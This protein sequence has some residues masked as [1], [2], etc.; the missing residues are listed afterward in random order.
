MNHAPKIINFNVKTTIFKKD[1]PLSNELWILKKK[2][3][4]EKTPYP[5]VDLGRNY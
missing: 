5:M 4:I 1:L 2:R 3:K